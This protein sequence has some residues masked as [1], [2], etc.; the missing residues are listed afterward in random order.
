[1]SEEK[2]VHC[3]RKLVKP[4]DLNPGDRLFGGRVLA[5]ADEAAATYAMCQMR[6]QTLVTKKISEVI[7]D[8]PAFNGDVLDFYCH[9]LKIGTTSLT[10]KCVCLRKEIF[11]DAYLQDTILQ[12]DFVFVN[13]DERGKPTPH[14]M[15]EERA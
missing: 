15:T 12:C 9:I 4:E 8:N 3:F 11:H 1:M 13:V 2:P 5:W 14:H 10:V 7:F 6:S